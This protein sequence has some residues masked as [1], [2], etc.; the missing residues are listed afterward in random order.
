M[1][2][3]ICSV[4][5]NRN[6]IDILFKSFVDGNIENEYGIVEYKPNE[7]LFSLFPKGKTILTD[8]GSL[9]P[10]FVKKNRGVFFERKMQKKTIK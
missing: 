8:W 4:S 10:D 1:D 2:R 7:R 9:K 3:I 6:G 5:K